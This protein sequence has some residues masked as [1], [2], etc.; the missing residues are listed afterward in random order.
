[1]KATLENVI[2]YVYKKSHNVN[3]YRNEISDGIL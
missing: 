3:V 1:M 2:D